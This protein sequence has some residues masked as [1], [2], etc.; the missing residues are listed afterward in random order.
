MTSDYW[1]WKL[2]D[3]ARADERKSTLYN[4]KY[5]NAKP[6]KA[7][8][9]NVIALLPDAHLELFAKAHGMEQLPHD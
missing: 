5:R 9:Y 7:V 2:S 4:M 6:L 1:C 8:D 3:L